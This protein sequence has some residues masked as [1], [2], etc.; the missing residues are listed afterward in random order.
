MYLSTTSKPELGGE[1][2]VFLFVAYLQLS[3]SVAD[4]Q[5]L[6]AADETGLDLCGVCDQRR[7]HAIQY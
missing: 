5:T 4:P 7:N 6:Y 1:K 2:K 3:T